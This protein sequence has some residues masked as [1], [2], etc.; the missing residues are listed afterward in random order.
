MRDWRRKPSKPGRGPAKLLT[1][2]PEPRVERSQSLAKYY[3][4]C[5]IYVLMM[6]AQQLRLSRKQ[7]GLTQVEAAARLGVSQPY[8]SQLERGGR[9]LTPRLARA[10]AKL[11]RLPPTVLPLPEEPSQG[12]SDDRLVRALAALGYPGYSH[13]PAGPRV[14]PTL[15]MS[16]ALSE[17][18]LDARVT[19]ALPWVLVRYPDLDW[20][21]LVTRAKLR[22]VQN[23]LGFLV[24]VA[25]DLADRRSDLAAAAARLA[26]VER[27]L[28]QSRLVAETTLSREA[29]PVAEREWLRVNRPPQARHW[30]V[31]T[32]LSADQLPY[33]A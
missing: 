15:L 31:L 5:N 8:L 9:T 29:M 27:A 17:D 28:E 4:L 30:N 11:Y 23:R 13:V 1:P 16:Q 12:V 19:E 3:R 26:E 20:E 21:W 14:N 2:R 24:G 25:R 32:S 33:A 6:T 7:A 18:N 10:T 22:N